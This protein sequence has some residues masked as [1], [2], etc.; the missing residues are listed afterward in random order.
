MARGV[1][2]WPTLAVLQGPAPTWIYDGAKVEVWFGERFPG[3][4]GEPLPVIGSDVT[5]CM[6]WHACGICRA[7]IEAANFDAWRGLLDRYG[8]PGVPMGLLPRSDQ[9]RGRVEVLAQPVPVLP[10]SFGLS[11][12]LAHTRS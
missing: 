10:V 3:F 4:E 8:E 2:R 7:P 12:A 6:D 11:A 5:G 1:R 9:L